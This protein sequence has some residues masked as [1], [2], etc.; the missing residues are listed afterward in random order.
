MLC[1]KVKK[2]KRK[3]GNVSK[4]TSDSPT[5]S[6]CEIG[7]RAWYF[8]SKSPVGKSTYTH[9]LV[10]ITENKFVNK[11]ICNTTGCLKRLQLI[12]Y[13]VLASFNVVAVEI[14]H[15]NFRY[16]VVIP[17][18]PTLINIDQRTGP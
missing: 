5:F 9:T 6:S 15:I 2:K 16:I 7:D 11:A 14:S 13:K 10:G 17:G 8:D 4:R 18:K 3:R 1:C 12:S